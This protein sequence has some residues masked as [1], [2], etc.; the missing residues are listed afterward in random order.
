MEEPGFMLLQPPEPNLDGGPNTYGFVGNSP[1]NYV[2]EL[3]LAYGNPVSGPNGPVSPADPYAP[4]GAYYVPYQRPPTCVESCALKHLLGITTPAGVAIT[5][6]GEPLIPKAKIPFKAGGA[7]QGTSIAG[8]V[9]DAI[10]GD[11]QLPGSWKTLQ[12]KGCCFKFTATKSAS[13]FVARWIPYVGVALIAYDA[14]GMAGCV[15]GC[16]GI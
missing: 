6:S 10:I 12:R 2:D 8:A 9:T 5:I 16:K 14:A 1:L 3:G 13:R 4:G 15:C 11:A 7:S